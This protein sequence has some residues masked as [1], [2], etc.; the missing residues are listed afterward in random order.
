MLNV[1]LKDLFNKK[2]GL[3]VIVL[4]IAALYFTS[5]FTLTFNLITILS[6][7]GIVTF[8]SSF[9]IYYSYFF[10]ERILAYYQL[11]I[12]QNIFYTMFLIAVFLINFLERVLI[13]GIVFYNNLTIQSAIYCILYSFLVIVY[14]FL[15][16]SIL[17]KKHYA[18]IKTVILLGLIIVP[19]LIQNILLLTMLIL[20]ASFCIWQIK[21]SIYIEQKK[22]FLKIIQYNNY[23][24][25]KLINEGS[26]FINLIFS[27]FF[28]G[29]LLTQNQ[30]TYVIVPLVFTIISI[31]SPLTTLIS[32]DRGMI[33]QIK[34]LPNSNKIYLM[35]LRVLLL[36]FSL[37]NSIV[38]ILLL[39]LGILSIN[40]WT[41]SYIAI[42]IVFES[43]FS[44]IIEI[45]FPIKNWHLKKEIWKSPRK[46]ILAIIIYLFSF[47]SCFLF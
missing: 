28:I 41:V 16:F 27:L 10:K 21:T 45:T 37:L 39:Y 23:F 6:S 3:Y 7:I 8:L 22:S 1:V 26:F 2:K 46:Y 17:Q 24:M 20:I 13:L 5:N 40:I 4:I 32:S 18:I 36:Y 15:T 34:L 19:I 12:R 9:Q 44:L 47:S 38:Y 43:L 30:N 14:S 29:Y 25:S 31:N 35:Y 11:P 33:K 42:L